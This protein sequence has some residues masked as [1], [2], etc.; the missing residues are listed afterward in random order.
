MNFS[1]ENKIIYFKIIF[2]I[3]VTLYIL[4]FCLFSIINLICVFIFIVVWLNKKIILI[5]KSS[6]YNRVNITFYEIKYL[7]IYLFFNFFL[8]LFLII[9]YDFFYWNI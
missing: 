9:I 4:C 8:F 5:N 6:K 3:C 2:L 7:D 1:F